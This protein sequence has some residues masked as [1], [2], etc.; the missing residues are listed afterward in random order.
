[1]P[2]IQAFGRER[3][4]DK[5]F[6]RVN[7]RGLRAGLRTTRLEASMARAVELLLAVGLWKL[8]VVV[9]VVVVLILLALLCSLPCFK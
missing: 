9:V 6:G 7:K 5:Q 2:L 1:M 3:L 8:V 4:R